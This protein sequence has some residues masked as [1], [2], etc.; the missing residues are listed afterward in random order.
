MTDKA[1]PN[2]KR[3]V[4]SREEVLFAKEGVD[5]MVARFPCLNTLDIRTMRPRG[6]RALESI[7]KLKHLKHLYTNSVKASEGVTT[8]DVLERWVEGISDLVSLQLSSCRGVSERSN[9]SPDAM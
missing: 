8:N 1:I 3:L 6:I 9:I 4:F 5:A 2:L 7:H